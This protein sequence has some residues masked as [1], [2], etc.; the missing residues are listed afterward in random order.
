[1]NDLLVPLSLVA[2]GV[3][4]IVV[5]MFVPSAGVLGI[6]AALSLVA[7][8][9][10]SFFYGGMTTGTVFMGSTIVGVGMLI[11]Y[12]VRKW[13]HTTL[14]RMILVEPPPPEELLPDRSE[15]HAMVG[16]TGQAVSLM[17]PSGFVEIEGKRFHASGETTIEQ[18][19]WVEVVSVRNGNNLIVRAIS[20]EVAI[21]AQ[22]ASQSGTAPRETDRQV[23]PLERP[24]SDVLDPFVED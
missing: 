3:F 7:G 24:V 6:L 20:E 18:G 14:G 16:R 9:I 13:P 5:E 19:A 15:L 1:M 2:L 12:L 22:S 21:R 10:S 4:F 8:V 17:L 23:D 11:N